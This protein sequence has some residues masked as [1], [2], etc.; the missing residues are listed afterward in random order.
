MQLFEMHFHKL[1]NGIK[2][3]HEVE[4]FKN[5]KKLYIGTFIISQK[6]KIT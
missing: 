6:E 2:C 3:L 5:K 1:Y 4:V